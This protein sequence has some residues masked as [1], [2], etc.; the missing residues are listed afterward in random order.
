MFCVG[1]ISFHRCENVM[2]SVS[3][4]KG[5]YLRKLILMILLVY[6]EPPLLGRGR[7]VGVG[8]GM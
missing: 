7:G 1:G 5:K 2:G 8:G 3:K 6:E 4:M